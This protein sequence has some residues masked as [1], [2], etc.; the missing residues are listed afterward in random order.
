MLTLKNITKDYS[1]AD[2]TVLALKG[3][4]LNFRKNE[5]V[6]V[7]GQSG[8]GKTTL[9]NIIGGLD[10]YSSGDL[11]IGNI[12]TKRYKDQ[13]WDAYRNYAIGFVFQSYNL[14][15]HL[16]V[17]ANVEMALTLSGVSSTQRK[18]RA[19]ESLQKV[20]LS[21]HI[22]KKPNQLSG[23]QMQRVAIARALVNDPQIILADEPTGALDSETSIE[24]MNILKAISKDK[25]II[26][27]THNNEI[28]ARY[29]SRIVSLKDGEIIGDTDPLLENTRMDTLN[30]SDMKKTAMSYFTALSLSFRNLI[31][32]KTRTLLTAFAGSIGIIGIALVLALSN[33]FGTYIEQMQL[34]TLS[35]MPISITQ[36]V[37]TPPIPKNVIFDGSMDEDDTTKG[38]V[39]TYEVN[40]KT[41]HTN[42]LTPDYLTYIANMDSTLYSN[43]MN[44]YDLELQFLEK[45]ADEYFVMSGADLG[46]QTISTN[47]LYID[48][49]FELVIG[50]IP[51]NKNQAVIILNDAHEINKEVM[52]AL[53]LEDENVEIESLIGTQLQVISNDNY[54]IEVDEQ[55]Q[56]IDPEQYEEAYLKNANQPLEIVGIFS[57]KNTSALPMAK[58]S[59][60][61]GVL[62]ELVEQ[63]LIVNETSDIAQMQLEKGVDYNVLTGRE[64]SKVTNPLTKVTVSAD[65]A[66]DAQLRKIGASTEPTTIQI[67]SASFESKDKISEYLDAY[68]DEKEV[69]D[70]VL[71]T[72]FAKLISE[73]MNILISTIT[74]V[75][76]AFAGISLVVSSVMIG[77]ITYV[78]VVERTKEIG[79]LRS[80]GARKKDISRV[81]NAE[82]A[83]VG[84]VAGVL[85]IV[86]TLLLSIPINIVIN[87]VI[88]GVGD[89]AVLKFE[90]AV[91]LIILS[92]VLT[93]L[94]GLIPSRIAAQK[95]PVKALRTD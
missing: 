73:S 55:F 5:F 14:I 8:S 47:P 17:L 43:K 4:S 60:G 92:I 6:A 3:V 87:N 37:R 57:E 58:D 80:L 20:G 77:I 41:S 64:F 39:S 63:M 78:S 69:E 10:T 86:T 36:V 91:I 94:A 33:G 21:A 81:F 62:T 52:E 72:D 9:L 54:Y 30:K 1:T 27:V 40:E 18:Q 67:Y 90:H 85:G 38:V 19:T 45:R 68:N 84:A 61:L 46:L 71:Y 50:T 44:T 16:S 2:N 15:S 31:T 23:G 42:I 24:I 26:M 13:D 53:G 32:K 49:Q 74:T 35:G 89:I 82:T 28:A 70:Q 75:L 56:G 65:A 76:V 22:N 93:L 25:L 11:L 7:L 34:E 83:I 66:Y 48:E 59:T 79:V 95:D 88:V 29:S 51:E 12:S